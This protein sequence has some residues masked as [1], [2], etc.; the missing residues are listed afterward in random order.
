MRVRAQDLRAARLALRRAA[1]DAPPPASIEPWAW[2][3]RSSSPGSG[4]KRATALAE[5]ARRYL[6]GHGPA[7]PL[8]LAGWAGLTLRDARAGLGTIVG[9]LV[10][11]AG[12]LLDLAAL[13][14]RVEPVAPRL[15]PAVDSFLLGWRDRSFAV[16]AEHAHEVHP[17]GGMIRATATV[18]GLAVVRWKAGVRGNRLAVDIDLFAAVGPA[19]PRRSGTRPPRS[20]ASKRATRPRSDPVA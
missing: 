9:E 19:A 14:R 18:D 2:K 16:P 3:G 7:T 20:R 15:L 8:D 6:A 1:S 13:D 4:S 5:L 10:E 17:G 12:G 11:L